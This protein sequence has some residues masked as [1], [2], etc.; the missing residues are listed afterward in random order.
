MRSFDLSSRKTVIGF[1]LISS[2]VSSLLGGG[3]WHGKT[4]DKEGAGRQGSIAFL[5]IGCLALA[6]GLV[7]LRLNN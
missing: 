2:T 1:M 5:I 7:V 6:I 3:F 4:K